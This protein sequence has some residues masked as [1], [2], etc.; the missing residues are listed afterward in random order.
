MKCYFQVMKGW[1]QFDTHKILLVV[2]V[3]F[4]LFLTQ[5]GQFVYICDLSMVSHISLFIITTLFITV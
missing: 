1:P 3:M 5:A 4:Q 2:F